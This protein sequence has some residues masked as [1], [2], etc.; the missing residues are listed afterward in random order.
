MV[1]AR[2]RPRGVVSAAFSDGGGSTGLAI[3]AAGNAYFSQSRFNSIY[4][5]S[6]TNAPVLFAGSGSALQAGSA[7]GTGNAAEFTGPNGIAIDAAG[8]LF[9]A[10]TGNYTIRK[11]T[12]AGVVTTLAGSASVRGTTDGSGSA[13]LLMG[14]LWYR[15]GL[16]TTSCMSPMATPYA[17][18]RQTAP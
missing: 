4:K 13:A 14:S 18:W 11:I 17:R 1:C 16:G 12:P 2:S 9:V 7:D 10:D 3:D 6:G 5:V 15:R 8:N